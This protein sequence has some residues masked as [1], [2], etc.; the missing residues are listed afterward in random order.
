MGWRN[1]ANTWRRL[2]RRAHDA[3]MDLHVVA[4]FLELAGMDRELQKHFFVTPKKAE[5]AISTLLR[6]LKMLHACGYPNQDIEVLVA[7]AA[8]YFFVVDAARRSAGEPKLEPD[9]FVHIV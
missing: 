1:P 8:V 6:C 2:F 9:E 7:H 4:R 3:E 5:R